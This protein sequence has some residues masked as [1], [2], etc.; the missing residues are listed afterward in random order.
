VYEVSHLSEGKSYCTRNVVVRHPSTPSFDLE[1]KMG[2]VRRFRVEEGAKELGAICFSCICSFKRD[3]RE[4][5]KGH[6]GVDVK[7]R[8][9]DVLGEGNG[10][11]A[12][13]PGVDAP[14]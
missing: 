11:W 1:G 10:S 7:E 9:K 2:E 8:W 13:A 6:Q 5:F 3:E 12:M 4:S 14:W